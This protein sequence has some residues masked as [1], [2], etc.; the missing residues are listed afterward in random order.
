[1]KFNHVGV[2]TT[3]RFEGE[4]DLSHLKVTVSD[5]LNNPFG[6]QS[7]WWRI[8]CYPVSTTGC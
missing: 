4:I 1:M 5:H 8:R 2:P 7:R 6:I 3:T